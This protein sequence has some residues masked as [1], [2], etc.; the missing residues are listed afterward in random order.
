VPI[1]EGAVKQ[2]ANN[3]MALDVYC[4]LAYRLHVLSGPT[5]V[6]W[7]AL[8]AQFGQG[9]GRLD[10]FRRKFREVLHLALAVYP[11]A[12]VDEEEHGLLLKPSRPPVASRNGRPTVVA[13]RALP[14]S[15]NP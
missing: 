14:K 15:T 9:F 13:S 11:D 2:I 8:Y 10:N 4:W 1:E 12:Q 5:P 6:S 7:R 3:S